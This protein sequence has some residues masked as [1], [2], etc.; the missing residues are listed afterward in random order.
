MTLASAVSRVD[1]V[2]NGSTDT[3]QYTFKIFSATDLLVTVR[4]TSGVETTLV[5]LTDYTVTGVGSTSGGDVV[6]TAGNLTTDYALTIRRVRSVTQ[7][8]DIRNQGAFYPEIHEDAM[9]HQV[10]LIQQQQDELARTIKLPETEAG[11]AVNTTLPSADSRAG[12]VLGFDGSGNPTA[13]AT[14]P[15][16]SVTISAFGESLIDDATATEARTTLG[17]SGTGG[18]VATAN[19]E[20]GAVTSDKIGADAVGATQLKDDA[21]VDGN[22]AVTTNHIR[23]GAITTAKIADASITSGK[24]SYVVGWTPVSDT[25]TYSTAERVVISGDASS[26]YS[27]GNRVKFTQS[28]TTK[29]FYI[30]A[31][32]YSSGNT[33]LNLIAG[34]DYTLVNAAIT[35]IYVCS[36]GNPYDFP[37][38]FN[39]ANAPATG[40]SSSTVT[41]SK[42][43][44]STSGELIYTF[45]ITGTSNSTST[46]ITLPHYTQYLTFSIPLII[47]NG[48]TQATPGYGKAIGVPTVLQIFRD[49]TELAWTNSG[50]K[51][52]R[53]TITYN[54]GLG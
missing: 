39:H 52:V 23:D 36:I 45:N 6:L 51:E 13:L 11:T 16:S 20:D 48:V 17:F 32:S 9:D 38:R 33:Y 25:W 40:W 49:S 42:F 26:R 37:L 43:T 35:Q 28:S 7:E 29:Y 34:S 54:V 53:A 50:T 15:E 12:M 31:V 44:L 47:N 27:A 21:S 3:Y 18:T 22:R 5:Y 10:M 8:T 4:D 2:G 14:I 19:I 1:Y 46:Y 24:L 41:Y 30:S